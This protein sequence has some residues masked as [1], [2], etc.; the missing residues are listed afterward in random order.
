M[1][2]IL[3]KSFQTFLSS[4]K[5]QTKIEA[6][7]HQINTEYEGKEIHFIGILDGAFMFVSDLLKHI[8]LPS[9]VSFI[10]LKSYQSTESSGLVSE[11]IG[12]NEELS[13]KHIIVLE[14][15]VDTGLTLSSILRLVNEENPASIA[16]A[17]LLFK[18][19]SF[20]GNF[21]PNYIGFEI[22]SHFIVGYGMD[23]NGYGRNLNSI[24]QIMG[25]DP[26]STL[27]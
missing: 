25:S 22:P 10:K 6:M 15:I 9:T 4:D 26:K 14:D 19:E 12:L 5:I 24:Y 23:Y 2:T 11:L 27:C 1:L 20:S 18:P 13:D 8:S 7:A 16:V 3:D 21:T 17:S